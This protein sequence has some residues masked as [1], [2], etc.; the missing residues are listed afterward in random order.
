MGAIEER[1]FI[2]IGYVVITLMVFL[3]L[4]FIMQ[5]IADDA[6]VRQEIYAVEFS[7]IGSSLL[8]NEMEHLVISDIDSDMHV[9][10]SGCRFDVDIKYLKTRSASSYYCLDNLNM[11]KGSWNLVGPKRIIFRNNEEDRRGVFI[12]ESEDE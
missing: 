8:D 12:I 6:Y 9:Y 4:F 5:K 3:S 2:W 11:D 10:F 1:S 7:F